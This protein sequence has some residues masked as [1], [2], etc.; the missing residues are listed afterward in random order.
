[1]TEERERVHTWLRRCL[2]QEATDVRDH[3]TLRGYSGCVTYVCEADAGRMV[4]KLYAPGCDDYS[5]L[6]PVGTARKHTLAL[7]ELP[8]LG[9]PAPR[10]LGF[11]ADGEEAAIAME[12]LEIEPVTPRGHLEAARVLA[13]LHQA[14]PAAL[15]PEL[16]DLVV[17]STP[18]RDRIGDAPDEPPLRET[19]LQHGDY[20]PPNL[21][22]GKRCL[23]VLDWDLLACGDPMWDLGFLVSA[24]RE[25]PAEEAEAVIAAYQEVRPIDAARLAWQRECWEGYWRRRDG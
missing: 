17:R 25:L 6:G 8:A 22:P 24:E 21:A 1:M 11:A 10:C 9:I 5:C 7:Q 20:F 4:L 15:S 23:R 13:R 19:A 12:W 16:A 18:N 3:R 14:S 2:R